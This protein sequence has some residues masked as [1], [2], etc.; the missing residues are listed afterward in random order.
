MTTHTGTVKFFSR[1]KGYGIID[2]DSIRP[3][4]SADV[5]V[6]FSDIEGEGYRNLEA[7]NPV[8][9][10]IEANGNKGMKAVNVRVT[11]M[12]ASDEYARQGGR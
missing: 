12:T 4:V 2:K 11:S 5:F 6:H 7:D 8:S 1:L 10:N 9:F 3:I